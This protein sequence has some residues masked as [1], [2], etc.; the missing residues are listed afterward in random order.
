M[1]RTGVVGQLVPLHIDIIQASKYYF[2]EIKKEYLSIARHRWEASNNTIW[3]KK[4]FGFRN[5]KVA[6]THLH[7]YSNMVL[8]MGPEWIGC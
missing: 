5:F 7:K 1:E 2:Q 8:S 6:S 4:A 3:N